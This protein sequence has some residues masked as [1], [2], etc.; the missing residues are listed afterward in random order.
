L[1]V[2]CIALAAV[3]DPELAAAK[4][5]GKRPMTV[6][7]LWAM[8]RVGSPAVSPDGRWVVFTVTTYSMTENK[9][10]GDL[11][12]VEASRKTPPRRLTSNK[13]ADSSPAWSHDGQRL[14]YVSKRGSDPAQLFVLS[15]A[16][17]EPE[18]ITTL[19]I[20]VSD[21]R[22][23]ADG[24]RIAFLAST[25]PGVD[26]DFTAVKQRLDEQEK[27]K[28]KAHASESRQFRAWDRYLDDETALPHIFVVDLDT[29]AVKDLLPG[30]AQRMDPEGPEGQ[31][32]LAP[33]G[34]EVAFAA[35]A[36]ESPHREL[37]SDIWVVPVTGGAP[38]RITA[39]NPADDTRPRYTPDGKSILYGRTRRPEYDPDFVRLARY[40]RASG[41]SQ[42]LAD[43][44]DAQPAGWTC[45]PDGKTVVF[46][47][48]ELGR[49]HLY[50]LPIGGGTPRCIARGG[51]TGGVSAG[52]GGRLVF[53]R[54]AID[55]PAELWTVQLDGK[56]L[57]ALTAINA[58]RVAQL[59]FG[60][61]R[62]V[63]FRGAGGDPVQMFV[64]LPPGY[65][66]KARYPL[67]Q[68]LHG[69]PH[70]AWVD[71]F[72][73][74]WNAALLASRGQIV[75]LVNF[76]GSTGAG[77]PFE[78][79]ILG[80][81]GDKPFTDIMA[82]TDWLIAE[83]LVDSERMAAGGGSYGGYLTDWILGHTD[84]FKAL[85]SHAGVYDLMAQF[86]S[87][88]T[89]GRSLN[90]GATPWEDPV[91]IDRWS[92]N[93]FADKFVTPTLILHGEKDF[94]VR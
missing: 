66:A 32:D 46:H 64:V 38:H 29:K 65:R 37:N 53:I 60:Q 93:R 67:F 57:R 62:D 58:E 61:V 83:G 74:R 41:T 7:D 11:W 9:G 17:G 42:G 73:Y 51:N 87:D 78:E 40:D 22:W 47:A 45:T 52:P 27:D 13:G 56:G 82:A 88:A 36:T 25:W 94:R 80:A 77:Q 63:T 79:S 2:L 68:V 23:F 1:A 72:H 35:N 28:T 26:A 84:R 30:F 43:A 31:W 70:G 49:N 48:T 89:W 6:E 33:D 50:T 54:D 92:P 90:Y 55:M 44:W 91:R 86:A 21:P 85:V 39:D 34:S 16:G 8:Q 59:D 3:L 71:Q 20:A 4:P 19:P 15:L 75:A 76:H 69:G 5:A 12:L 81:H 10:Q 24:K 14:A 18:Q